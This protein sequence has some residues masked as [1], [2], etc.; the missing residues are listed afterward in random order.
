MSSFPFCIKVLAG[1]IYSSKSKSLDMMKLQYFLLLSFIIHSYSS[2]AFIIYKEDLNASRKLTWISLGGL[3]SI[4]ENQNGKC[5]TLRN[6][7]V[8]RVEAMIFA[9]RRINEDTSILPN[10]N[11]TFEIRDTCSIPTRALQQALN[12]I[13]DQDSNSIPIS[14]VMGPTF[15]DSSILVANIWDCLEFLKLVLHQQQPL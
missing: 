7:V 14:A 8:E 12:Y 13:H 4:H 2:A 6:F 11:L 5:G 15:S 3:F 10:V 1:G 9:I